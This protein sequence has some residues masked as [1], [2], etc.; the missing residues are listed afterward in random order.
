VAVVVSLSA[1]IQSPLI[2]VRVKIIFFKS[3][4]ICLEVSFSSNSFGC[5]LLLCTVRDAVVR[6]CITFPLEGA[7]GINR[8]ISVLINELRKSFLPKSIKEIAAAAAWTWEK[9]GTGRQ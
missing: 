3:I 1:G 4:N 2:L 5:T 7:K 6:S 8:L 9:Y